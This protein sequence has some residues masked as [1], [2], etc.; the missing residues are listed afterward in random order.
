MEKQKIEVNG[1][2]MSVSNDEF[3]SL[4]ARGLIDIVSAEKNDVMVCK[5]VHPSEGIIS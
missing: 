5:L 3:I 1:K 2:R 4:V